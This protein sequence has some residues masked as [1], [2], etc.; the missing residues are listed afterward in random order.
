M[1]KRFLRDF[2]EEVADRTKGLETGESRAGVLW[3]QTLEAFPPS[4]RVGIIRAYEYARDIPYHHPGLTTEIYFTHVLRV[5]A[6]AGFASSFTDPLAVKIGL[7]HNALETSTVST[8][9]L[10]RCS[11]LEV[12]SAVHLL[13][14]DRSREWDWDYK[15]N[16]YLKI[17]QAPLSVRTVK[18]VD[19]MDN[20]FLL[21]SNPDDKTKRK[22]RHELQRHVLPLALTVG[23]DIYGLL[24]QLTEFSLEQEK[25]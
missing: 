5:A 17:S 20:L 9:D 4:Q 14:V 13:T 24:Q 2:E 1:A 10:V 7:L 11:S 25:G 23:E 16:Y 15:A 21:H 6:Y 22:Y 12:A 19:K 18:V 3:A 8:Q